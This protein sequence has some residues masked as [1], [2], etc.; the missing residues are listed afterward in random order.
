MTD[1]GAVHDR[2]GGRRWLID[3]AVPPLLF[4]VANAGATALGYA[5]REL[6]LAVATAGVLRSPAA[7]WAGCRAP[8][9]PVCS[10][11]CSCS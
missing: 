10:A 4:S 7:P 6:T 8:R 3:E 5:E 9:S 2:L 1:L 11:V